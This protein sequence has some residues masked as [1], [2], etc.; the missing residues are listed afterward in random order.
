MGVDDKLMA[1]ADCGPSN[2]LAQL[3]KHANRDYT[4]SNV[5]TGPLQ[6]VSWSG[7]G[8]ELMG[9]FRQLPDSEG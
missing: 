8:A 2:P 9:G 5:R 7:L 6:N 3:Q 4:Q 1:E